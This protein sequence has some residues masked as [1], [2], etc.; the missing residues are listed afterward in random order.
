M[1]DGHDLLRYFTGDDRRRPSL[2]SQL[3]LYPPPRLIDNHD[4]DEEPSSIAAATALVGNDLFGT[5]NKPGLSK[6]RRIL[7]RNSL[8]VFHFFDGPAGDSS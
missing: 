4:D 5:T 1:G 3:V 6:S 7:A 2:S 8:V